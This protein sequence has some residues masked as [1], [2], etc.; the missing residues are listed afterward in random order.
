MMVKIEE[1]QLTTAFQNYVEKASK[2]DSTIAKNYQNFV[3]EKGRTDSEIIDF[4]FDTDSYLQAFHYSRFEVQLAQMYYEDVKTLID[5]F[6]LSP[7]TLNIE[8]A[9]IIPIIFPKRKDDKFT[10]EYRIETL[11]CFP[12]E[13]K[14]AKI[15]FPEN[16]K[17][18]FDENGFI[19]IPKELRKGKDTR[20]DILVQLA[21]G[22]DT[23]LNINL[24][25]ESRKKYFANEK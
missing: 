11:T 9:Q 4:Y 1:L 21:C 6:S 19:I 2:I 18:T 14:K 25:S 22:K 16:I 5:K 15:V 20:F 12:F 7:Y 24:N 17:T 8:D 13:K 3:F 23:I 10:D